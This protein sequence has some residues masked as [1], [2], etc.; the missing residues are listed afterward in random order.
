[1]P[2]NGS[3]TFSLAQPAFVP[4]TTISSTAVNSD[5]SDIAANGL[6]KCLTID[7]QNA[8]TGQ[9]SFINGTAAA[10]AITFTSDKTTG[11]YYPG[12]QQ[13]GLAAGGVGGIIVNTANVGT[14]QN[15]NILTYANGAFPTPVGIISDFA[16]TVAPTGWFLCFGQAFAAASYPELAQVIGTTYGGSSSNPLV[17]DLRGRITPGVDNMGGVAANRIGTIVTDSGTIVGTTQGSTGG[18]ATHVLT[19]TES[20]ILTYT[21]TTTTSVSA[22]INGSS[23]DI[24]FIGLGGSQTNTYPAGTLGAIN[25]FSQV[26][27]TSPSTSSTASN[28]GGGA[29]SLLQPSLMMNKIIFAGRP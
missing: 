7:G 26:S 21:T 15:G 5:L 4:G 19:A 11:I 17:P 29:L 8:P 10:P 22:S 16:G 3:G 12:A 24:T 6:S 23:A 18:S 9:I 28:A 20:A 2:F 13:L 1:M 25:N 27:F 14:G